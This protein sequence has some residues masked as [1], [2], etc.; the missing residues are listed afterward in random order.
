MSVESF[1]ILIDSLVDSHYKPKIYT[2][3]IIE[4]FKSLKENFLAEFT[5]IND[6]FGGA[7]VDDLTS[8]NLGGWLIFISKATS[9]IKQILKDELGNCYV[10]LYQHI[11]DSLRKT[12]EIHSD[13]SEVPFDPQGLHILP[14]MINKVI[15]I[16]RAKKE[17]T[18][19]KCYIVIDAIRNPY[20]A[21]F[22]KDRYSAFYLISINAPT[23]DRRKYLQDKYRFSILQIEDV[24]KKETG[25]GVKGLKEL[26][27][28][29]VKK[30]IEI[31][32]I[33]IFN[34]RNEPNNHNILKA[35][36]AWYLSLIKH[37][38]LI[39]PTS[40]ERVMQIAYTAK[41][42]SGCISRQVGAVVTDSN[43]SIKA[44]GWND[45][46]KGQVPC[47]LRSLK[48][49]TNFTSDTTYSEYERHSEKFQK[50]ANEKLITLKNISPGKNLSYCFKSLQNEID[51][52]KNQVHTRSLHAEEN[53]FLQLAKYGSVG[54]EGGKLFTT[55][56]PC[57]L[58][59][60]KAYQLGIKEI[61]F[62]DPYPGIAIEHILHVGTNP[63][64]LIQ[65][66]GA[67]GKAYQQ[68]YEPL[69]PYKD[70]LDFLTTTL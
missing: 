24:D 41:L 22:F 4:L 20:E 53:A 23:V 46:A 52:E 45:V 5:S 34:P 49:V 63:P 6:Y 50:K 28:P 12:K 32:D 33:H 42:N 15:K 56:S 2:S 60:K 68:L 64:Q 25:N 21:K 35:Q 17:S 39:T 54:I 31:S 11:G 37:P 66:R 57:E 48:D 58:C 29:N 27:I 62:I 61:V 55:A 47:N 36:L 19:S 43:Y 30:C 67:I 8:L 10:N 3:G 13:F 38:G 51:D 44:V 18:Q 40:L 9:D 7:K 26:I 16:H 70:E 1:E 65:F 14:Q 69:M 59:A